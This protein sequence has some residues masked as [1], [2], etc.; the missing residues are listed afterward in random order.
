MKGGLPSQIPSFAPFD[1]AIAYVPSL[2]LYLDGTAEHT[3][4]DELPRMDIGALGMQVNDGKPKLI[5]I[6]APPAD[7]NYVAREVHARVQK[8]G[9]SK[10]TLDYRAAGYTAADWR[11]QYAADSARRER[12]NHDLGSEMPG[13]VLAPG[14]QGVQASNLA[15]ARQPATL[16]VEGTA[17]SFARREGKQLS[18]SVTN[19][20]RLTSSYASLSQRK[21]DVWIHV[22][23]ELRDDFTVELPAGA[24]V[25]SAPDP[26]RIDTPFGYYSLAIEVKPDRVSVKG[27]LGLRVPRVKPADYPAFKRFCEDVDRALSQRLVIEP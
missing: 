17:P 3:G 26:A 2:D 25:I 21:Q 22:F 7:K 14:N 23:S 8:S 20:L 11:R 16:H 18:M 4:I 10:L 12:I 15:D 24:R 9:E 19:S 5:T 1:H 6:P 13:F 27:R